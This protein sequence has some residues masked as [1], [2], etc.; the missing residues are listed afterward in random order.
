VEKSIVN[1]SVVSRAAI[2]A[3]CALLA[4]TA[5]SASAQTLRTWNVTSGTWGTTTSWDGGVAANSTSIA[6][7][8]GAGVGASNA[9]VIL[10]TGTSV[11]GMSFNNS[12]TTQISGGGTQVFA[13]GTNGIT[14]AVGAGPVAIGGVTGSAVTMNLS[15]TQT[16]TNNST[17]LLSTGNSVTTASL[18]N[19]G[20]DTLLT[21]AGSGSTTLSTL[22]GGAAGSGRV[23]SIRKEGAGLLR[24]SGNNTHAGGITLAGGTL[25][26]ANNGNLGT[27]TFT[28]ATNGVA[29]DVSAARTTTNNN[30]QAWNGDFTFLGTSTLDLG[31]GTVALG[32]NR[33][34]TVNASTLTVGGGIVDGGSGYT[35]TKAGAGALTLTASNSYG[36]KTTLSAGTLNANQDFALGSGTAGLDVNGGTLN[37]ASGVNV[38]RTGVIT[39]AGGT[40][41]SGTLTNNGVSLVAQSGSMSSVLAGSAGVDKST[42]GQFVL[43]GANTYAG[44]TTVSSGTLTAA[45]ALALGSDSAA[46]TVNTGGV[47]SI[48]SGVNVVRTGAV[49]LAGGTL[50]TGTLTLNGPNL[51]AQS[52]GATTTVIAGSAGITKTVASGTAIL[53]AV[54]TYS[55]TTFVN[56]GRLAIQNGSALGS[57]AAGTVVTAGGQLASSANNLTLPENLT[58]TGTGFGSPGGNYGA[59]T[60]NNNS[61]QLTLSGTVT[62]DGNAIIATFLAGQGVMTINNGIEGTGNV[63]L[64]A[65]AANNGRST[66][67][68]LGQSTYTGSTTFTSN[69]TYTIAG[70]SNVWENGINNALPTSTI[71]TMTVLGGGTAAFNNYRLAGFNQTLAGLSGGA[72]GGTGNVVTQMITG[73]SSTL[74]TLTVN[75]VANHTFAGTVGGTT[76]VDDNN[77]KFV[78]LGTGTLTLTASNSF[79]GGTDLNGGVLAVGNN[80]ALG[81]GTVT[82]AGGGL[83][84][85]SATA[86]TI[87]N[88]VSFTG[89]GTVGDS[90]NSGILTLTGPVDLGGAAR[91]LTVLSTATI[92]GV[93]SNGSFTKSGGAFLFLGGQNTYAGDTTILDSRIL[94]GTANALPTTTVLRFGPTSNS[95]RLEL[96]GFNQ[97][98]AGVDSTAATG[99]TLILQAAQA[100]TS[101]KPATLA[102]NVASG[103]SFTFSGYVRDAQTATNSALTIVKDGSGTQVFSGD[104]GLVNYT[105]A[106]TINAGVLEFSGSNSVAN[107]SAI[108]LGGGTVRFS[109][110]GTRS[111]TIVGTGGVEK[112][113][114][115][116]LTL[117]GNNTYSGPTAVDVGGLLVDGVHGGA[118]LVTVANA[119]RF[120]GDGSLGG[121]LTLLSGARFIFNPLTTLDVTGAVTLDNSFSV[122]SL[123]N[124][125]GSAIDWGAVADGT[126]TLVNTT[127]TFN[128][129]ANFGSGNAANIGGGRTAYFQNGSLQLV[130]VPEPSALLLLGLGAGG[131]A[132]LRRRARSRA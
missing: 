120:G 26:L 58:L 113:G 4:F 41:T 95:R 29:I 16:W 115:N 103:T 39:I 114:A 64:H 5:S 68:L 124:S 57:T 46:L 122:T 127:S 73:G 3:A 112:T 23:I 69:N 7:F 80:S 37:I 132:L 60:I 13:L 21:I 30:P 50:T 97:T 19:G 70:A 38:V 52:S 94:S 128:N 91:T 31:T 2:A 17:S 40:V 35:L 76:T 45:N 61:G 10:G 25:M 85:S 24:L 110:G 125:D 63:T 109:G 99:G 89:D 33:T 1:P 47:L 130:I 82:F 54:N 43:A 49:T 86:R 22:S 12:G 56:A 104:S 88:P 119:A 93:I 27:G 100:G 77:L 123:V 62:V 106:T 32:G 92:S 28:I 116:L 118:G 75:N 81:D 98:L 6:Y 90:T 117:S 83:S 102:L 20:T 65:G 67:K 107:P 121:G 18:A 44:A 87:A 108:T 34:V 14:M 79:T 15:G 78:K 9:T 105:G 53:N 72:T 131:A 55:G 74:S 48:L 84:S 71:L 96:E 126:Y 66:F 42:T 11:L 36:G 129:I 101:N 111:N 51:D 8:S 59:L